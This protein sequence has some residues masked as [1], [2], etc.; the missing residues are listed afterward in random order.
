[1]VVSAYRT[2]DMETVRHACSEFGVLVR[3]LAARAV[4]VPV[5]RTCGGKSVSRLAEVC[6]P[7]LEAEEKSKVG[8][9]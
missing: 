6:W 1:M 3:Y 2:K 8:S 4:A 5:C 9:G 7:C